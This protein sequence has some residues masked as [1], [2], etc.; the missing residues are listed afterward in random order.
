VSFEDERVAI[1]SRFSDNYSSTG[2]RYENV[3][4]VQPDST[5][6]VAITILS[7]NGI[8]ASIGTGIGSRL[9][10]FSG[11]VQ[12]DIY[13]V[14][15]GGTKSARQ[16]ADTIAAIFDNVQ[17]SSGSSG[18]ITMRT[19]SYATLGVENGWHHSVVSVAYHRSK[20]S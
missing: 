18:T 15:D 12:I 13:T 8:A 2:I 10:R 17:F 4:F 3:P 6:W 19:P 11:I 7:G 14:E 5:N 16:L 1:E 20:F 9:D